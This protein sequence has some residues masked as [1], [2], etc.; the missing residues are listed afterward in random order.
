MTIS[1]T[2]GATIS[3]TVSMTIDVTIRVTFN[4]AV[5]ISLVGGMC[6]R[7][8]DLGDLGAVQV[9]GILCYI[10]LVSDSLQVFEM[11]L[12]PHY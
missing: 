12:H 4:M 8:R 9:L 1:V 3:V 10:S 6:P 2:I 7:C 5:A 11:R